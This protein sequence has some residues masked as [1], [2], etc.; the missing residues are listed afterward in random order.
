MYID[1]CTMDLYVLFE[2]RHWPSSC[3]YLFNI[4]NAKVEIPGPPD[5]GSSETFLFLNS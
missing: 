2:R 4:L 5:P 1:I 3:V